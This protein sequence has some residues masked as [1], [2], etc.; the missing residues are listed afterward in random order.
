MDWGQL[1]VWLVGNVRCSNSSRTWE[2]HNYPVSRRLAEP[3]E[4]AGYRQEPLLY[5]HDQSGT[6]GDTSTGKVESTLR[7]LQ[8]LPWL[9]RLPGSHLSGLWGTPE[10]NILP[11]VKNCISY[12]QRSSWRG[13]ICHRIHLC[14]HMFIVNKPRNLISLFKRQINWLGTL[15]IGQWRVLV[16]V[17]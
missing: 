7:D 3:S 9:E 4:P 14:G 11:R 15:W 10:Y 17:F 8:R 13:I 6:K 1:Q 5:L 2:R 16:D 12:D